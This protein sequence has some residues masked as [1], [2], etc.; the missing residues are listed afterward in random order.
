[1]EFN[2]LEQMKRSII[3]GLMLCLVA[4]AVK[5]QQNNNQ[6]REQSI[7]YQRLMALIDAFYVDTVNLQQLTEDAIVKVLSDLDPHSV[8]ISK[9]EVEEM[10]EPLEGEFFGI[11]IQFTVFKDTLMVVSVVPGGPSEKVGLRPGDRIV[12]VDG[13]NIAGV[14][15]TNTGVRKRLKGEKGTL[16]KIKVLRGNEPMDFDI[17]RDRIPLYSVDAAY[18]LD[19][20]TGY[21]KLSRFAANT[22]EEFEKAVGK[23]KLEGMKDLILDLQGN[24]G[25][26]MG[27]AIGISDNF[28]DAGKMIVYTQ[29]I[30]SGKRDEFATSRGL[31][32]NGRVVI[33]VDENSASASEIVAGAVQD[34]DRGLIVGRRSFGKGLVQRPFPLT[35]GS[36]IRLTTAHYYTPSGKCIQ[37]PYTNEDYRGEL[38]H[39]YMNG[40]MVSADSIH[41]TDSTKYY[42]QTKHR[43]VYG[44]GG[45]IPD[46]FVPID[47]G[48]NYLY[49]NRLI[50]KNVIG[51]Y[52]VDFLDKN[53]AKLEKEYPT[54]EK[55]L[56]E[57]VVTDEMIEEIVR[58]G[59]KAGIPRD[60]KSL[61]K[62]LPDM[63]RQIKALIARDK[64]E[65]NEL[66]RV[67]NEDNKILDAG[68]KALKDGTYEA[69][70]K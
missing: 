68:L 14:K 4:F 19:K 51:E 6:V 11:G 40:E 18:M 21:I 66:Y 1:M 60:D 67:L 38:Y 42:T 22:V 37:K 58:L 62:V 25:G 48:I 16:V 17:I 27:A 61:Q 52:E 9:D 34:W 41:I 29:G 55:F 35:D 39:R 33:L 36:I 49:L 31:M 53:R 65:M 69:K 64:W 57:F 10:N 46:L 28:L 63:K 45:I 7:K 56:K 30:S 8:Y 23:M 5:A 26:Y 59:E 13:E 3:L 70:L 44:G 24:G 15:L 20:T 32:E 2:K 12:T 50:A 47:T 43:V 54:F